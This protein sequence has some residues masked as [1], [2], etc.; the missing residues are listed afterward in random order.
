M[1]NLLFTMI[2][3][4]FSLIACKKTETQTTTSVSDSTV[5]QDSSVTDSALQKAHTPAGRDSINTKNHTGARK[6]SN[7]NT[8]NG[9][10]NINAAVSDSARPKR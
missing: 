6:T 4:G 8:G 7:N 5:I 3:I 10:G 9:S 2:A 1:K